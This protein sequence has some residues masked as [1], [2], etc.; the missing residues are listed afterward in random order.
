MGAA[1]H[2]GVTPTP[3]TTTILGRSPATLAMLIESLRAREEGTPVSVRVVYN[4]DPGDPLR[5][6]APGVSVTECD[7]E[8]WAAN[9]RPGLGSGVLCG[10]YRPAAKQAVEAFFRDHHGVQ[11]TDYVCCVHPAAVPASSVIL[12]SG[13]QV[14]PL[15]VLAPHAEL[16]DFVT[17]NRQASVGHHTHIGAFSTLNPGVNVAG[18][19]TLGEAVT[20]GMG[21]N[22]V[23][24]VRIG[25]G[26]VVA[27]G[28]LVTRDVPPRALVMG[29]P[30]R[31]RE[32]RP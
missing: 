12:G 15:A 6:D 14:E 27:A 5:F 32:P 1:S 13:V 8:R 22:V 23:D 20:V 21:A 29:V 9:G 16:G 28:A 17:V 11:A 2:A 10:V 4:V 26:A 30:A 19:C 24:G 31:I 25:D 7:H 18:H 3:E